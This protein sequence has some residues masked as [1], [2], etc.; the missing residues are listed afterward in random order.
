MERQ[1]EY[2]QQHAVYDVIKDIGSGLNEKRKGYRKLLSRVLAN[3]I[4]KVVVVYQDRLTRFGFEVLE[5]VFASHGT[6]IE[7]LNE[8]ENE[9]KTP[10]QELVDDL[11]TS[12]AHCSGKLYGLRSHKY[13]EVISHAKDLFTVT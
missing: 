4:A 6:Q 8:N 10:Q 3:E 1:V 13:K 11:I 12:I 9:N 2:L 7:V 5:D